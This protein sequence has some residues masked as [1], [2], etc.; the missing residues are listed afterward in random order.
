MTATISRAIGWLLGTL[1]ILVPVALLLFI[2][3][4]LL[5][6]AV[7][8]FGVATVTAVIVFLFIV[9]LIVKALSALQKAE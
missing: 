4:L 8:T 2:A 3:G 5:N 7:T 1:I 9:W 6:I